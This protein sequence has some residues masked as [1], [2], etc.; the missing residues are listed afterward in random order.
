MSGAIA[1]PPGCRGIGGFWGGAT[2]DLLVSVPRSV[3]Q[4]SPGTTKGP[5]LARKDALPNVQH[6]SYVCL[7]RRLANSFLEKGH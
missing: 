4:A 7:R 2:Y 5:K 1:A 3:A 6:S